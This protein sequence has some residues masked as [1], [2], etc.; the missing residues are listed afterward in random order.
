MPLS[1]HRF[2]PEPKSITAD[3]QWGKKIVKTKDGVLHAAPDEGPD[4]MVKVFAAT[5][6]PDERQRRSID[7]LIRFCRE[8]DPG[9]DAEFA[10]L[11]QLELPL[12]AVVTDDGTLRA[13][14]LPNLPQACRTAPAGSR[15]GQQSSGGADFRASF[16]ASDDSIAGPVTDAQRWSLLATFAEVLASMHAAGLVHGD[17]DDRNVLCKRTDSDDYPLTAYLRNCTD[18]YIVDDEHPAITVT[19]QRIAAIKDPYSEEAGEVRAATDVHLLARWVLRL[20]GGG[21]SV[22]GSKRDPLE[23]LVDCADALGPRVSDLVRVA[24]GPI[25]S[26]P[27]ALDFVVPLAVRFDAAVAST[28]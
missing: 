14:F 5:A 12:R 11:D 13:V 10:L 21:L 22:A 3:Q 28:S 25:D 18:A 4:T 24:L 1:A 8:L 17:L 26:R 7:E 2:N 23:Q 9:V 16:L 19:R 20:F 6:T 15:K 27:G